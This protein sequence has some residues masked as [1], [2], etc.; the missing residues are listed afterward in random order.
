MRAKNGQRTV[1]F[2]DNQIISRTSYCNILD[3]HAHVKMAFFC[4]CYASLFAS[5]VMSGFSLFENTYGMRGSRKFCQRR[6]N[7]DT[8]SF[9]FMRGSHY[10]LK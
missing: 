10:K 8:I 5:A 2:P 1:A 9:K 7:F 6:S 3:W 4:L